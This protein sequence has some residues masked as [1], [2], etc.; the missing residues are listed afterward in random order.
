[1]IDRDPPEVSIC[2]PTLGIDLGPLAKLRASIARHTPLSYEVII[3]D[4]GG[5]VRGFPVPMNQALRAARART[6][7]GLNDDCEVT[8]G[9]IEPLVDAV[10][11]GA[12]VASPDQTSTD[13][14]QCICGWC[15][16]FD[17]FALY[18]SEDA[19]LAP[20]ESGLFYDEQFG[21]WAT[22]VDLCK[23][24]AEAGHPPV[25]VAI[26]NPLRHQLNATTS[27]PEVQDFINDEAV[28]DLDRYEAKWGTRAEADKHALA[29]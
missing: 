24:L 16:A 29:P 19:D 5:T 9:W 20:W 15:V 3:V 10:R 7:V 11:A 17:R 21:I 23:R 18:G 27:R 13:G 4:S 26:P 12:W 22:D 2:I 25:R 1:M 8:E 6:V 14:N 28:V